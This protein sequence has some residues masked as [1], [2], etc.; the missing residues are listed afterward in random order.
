MTPERWER[1]QDLYHASRARPDRE[2]AEFLA[3]VC[4]GDDAL[5]RE[6]QA[7]LDQ[8]VATS[9]FVDFIGGPAPRPRA[10]DPSPLTGQRL[11]SYQVSSLIGRGGMGE[12]YR[13]H[14]VK[15][16]RD[17][18]IKVLPSMFVSDRER[19]AR[20]DSEARMLAALNHPHIG[21]I[22][23]IEAAGRVPALVL[24]LVEGETLADRLRRG[25]IAPRDALLIARQIADALDAAH[26]KG[27]VHR[28]LKPGE[29][30]DHA[31]RRRQGAGLRPGEG[32]CIGSRA[33]AGRQRVAHCRNRNNTRG[34]DSRNRGLHEPRAGVRYGRGYARRCM[35]VRLRAV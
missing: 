29:H 32:R 1:I 33:D 13:A 19:L 10:S 16:G 18:A 25:P 20:F 22:Y 5:R 8:P 23:G 28:D 12:V 30:Q 27:I 11:G 21:A 6:V 9:S 15:L 31:G 7:L 4:A 26:Q 17:V 24:E 34:R 14:D 35:G 2:R 3:D